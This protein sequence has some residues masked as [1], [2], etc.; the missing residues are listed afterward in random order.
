MINSG[1]SVTKNPVYLLDLDG[2]FFDFERNAGLSG[3]EG[4]LGT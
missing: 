1:I 3:K 4:G 2:E